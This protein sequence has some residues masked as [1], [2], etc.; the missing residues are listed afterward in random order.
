LLYEKKKSKYDKFTPIDF[1]KYHEASISGTY[2]VLKSDII[3]LNSISNL[4]SEISDATLRDL[5]A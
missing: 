3:E 1:L 4:I 5:Y 2:I